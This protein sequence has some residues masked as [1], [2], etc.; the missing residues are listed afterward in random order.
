ME[1]SNFIKLNNLIPYLDDGIRVS[2]FCRFK[3]MREYQKYDGTDAA[4]F[5]PDILNSLCVVKIWPTLD[6]FKDGLVACINIAASDNVQRISFDPSIFSKM[7]HIPPTDTSEFDGDRFYSSDMEDN[8]DADD[9]HH[10]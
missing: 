8:Q 5:H 7:N 10:S 6:I 9:N 4:K 3:G 2:I 1:Q